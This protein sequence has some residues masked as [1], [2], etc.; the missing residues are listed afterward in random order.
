MGRC[1]AARHQSG[2]RNQYLKQAP[3]IHRKEAKRQCGNLI[4]GA[5]NLVVCWHFDYS[6]AA[7][8]RSS[9]AAGNIKPERGKVTL[10]VADDEC[11][12]FSLHYRILGITGLDCRCSTRDAF[13]S[14]L[15]L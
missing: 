7:P 10:A 12:P 11:A 2:L 13:R 5:S 9:K 8:G 3:L 14:W 15:Y 4:G 6:Q 1:Y